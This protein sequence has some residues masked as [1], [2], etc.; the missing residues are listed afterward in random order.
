MKK[1]SKSENGSALLFA[2][3]TLV[4]VSIIGAGVLYNCTTRYNV[5]SKQVKAWNEALYAAEAGADYGFAEVRKIISTGC[6]TS[7]TTC[8]STTFSNDSWAT[9]TPAPTPG[10]S[11]TYKSAS[12]P[13]VSIQFGQNNSQSA[14]VTVDAFTTTNTFACYR[15]R[16][17]GTATLSGLR[18][19]GM[20]DRLMSQADT[21]SHFVNGSATRG[22][23]DSLVR[24]IDF[25]YD[26][27]LATYGDGD[28]NSKSLQTVQ[29][30]QV[31][32]RIETVAVPQWAITGALKATGSFNGPGSSGVID[33]YDSKNGAYSFVANNP[34]SS[35]YSYSQHGDVS[36]GTS[37][38]TEGGP[39]YGNVTTN[40]GN[41]T[42]SG[43][44]I[45]GTIDNSVPFTFP[46]LLKPT[47]PTG[48]TSAGSGSTTISPTQAMATSGNPNFYVT[49]GSSSNL[50]IN[51]YSSGGKTYETHV[52]VVVNGDLANV[53]IAKGVV[54]Q[55]YFTGDFSAKAKD[56]VNNN[57][58]GTWSDIYQSDGTTTSSLVSRAAALQFYGVSP[59]DGSYESINISPPGNLWA[60]VYAPNGNISLTGNPDW[61]GAIVCHNFNGNGNT[62]FHY[63]METNAIGGIPVDYQVA[64]YVE[65]VR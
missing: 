59:T 48:Y 64:S 25:S 22:S 6:Q 30:P 47:Y 27:F 16:S 26:H 65:D 61:Y 17:V 18:R 31:T 55:I 42:H 37:S 32:R 8:F 12:N 9:P 52:T 54:A 35:Y 45:S 3:L 44:S 53:T 51:A 28:G 56:I 2:F 63:D 5:T 19:M 24:K 38:F 11:Y 40:G 39:I 14:T 41:V 4:I 34:A 33:S 36:V 60:I 10:P 62:G 57:V 15:I 46:P 58:D 43:T 1:I 50:T 23:G 49:S 29:S 20:D 13:S 7:G 21:T